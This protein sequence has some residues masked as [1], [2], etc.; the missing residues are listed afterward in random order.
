VQYTQAFLDPGLRRDD[1]TIMNQMS[2]IICPCP[3]VAIAWKEATP[4]A[5]RPAIPPAGDG[6]NGTAVTAIRNFSVFFRGFRGYSMEIQYTN[7]ANIRLQ[8]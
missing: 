7:V 2:F 8:G 6:V 5:N 3:S 1:E 4:A